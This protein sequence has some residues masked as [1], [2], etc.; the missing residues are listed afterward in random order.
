M[1][2]SEGGQ[3]V[4]RP[5]TLRPM[6]I[7][8]RAARDRALSAVARGAAVTAILRPVRLST[9][10]CLRS[11]IRSSTTILCIS[12]MSR[13]APPRLPSLNVTYRLL[14]AYLTLAAE[15][16]PRRPR[17]SERDLGLLVDQEA[18]DLRRRIVEAV[19]PGPGIHYPAGLGGRPQAPGAARGPRGLGRQP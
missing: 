4:Q 5:A 3:S 13:A 8:Q 12:S 10:S 15:E 19:A 1:P 6:P 14:D 11:R 9:A 18:L 7:N 16:G 17:P 2:A